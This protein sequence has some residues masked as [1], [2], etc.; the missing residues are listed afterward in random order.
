MPRDK[1]ADYLNKYHIY[2]IIFKCG[3]IIKLFMNQWEVD[4]AEG[5]S[6]SQHSKSW[7]EFLLRDIFMFSVRPFV[8]FKFLKLFLILNPS[9]TF[10]YL[11]KK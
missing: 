7:F 10:K 3:F 8:S 4:L 2:H 9:W 5:V 6:P 1:F 11:N